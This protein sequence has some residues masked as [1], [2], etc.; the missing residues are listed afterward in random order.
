MRQ[1]R[2]VYVFGALV[3]FV[4]LGALTGCANHITASPTQTQNPSGIIRALPT[5][6][7]AAPDAPPKILAVQLSALH[8]HPGDTWTGNIITTT[9]V[10]SLEVRAP[11][12]TFNA[13]HVG[14]G[15]F[16]FSI[17]AIFIPPIY[18]RVYTVALI[19]RNTKGAQ[20]EH[21]T[22]VDFH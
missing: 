16:A 1:F 9:N 7:I 19:A 5:P 22:D 17:H 3:G 10:A 8:V 18:R 20:A 6:E 4:C 11:S 14:P 2:K 15:E 12:F 21:D 13:E